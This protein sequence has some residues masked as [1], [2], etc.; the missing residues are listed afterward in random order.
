MKPV[1]R[2]FKDPGQSFFLFG[3]RGTGKSTWIHQAH[4]DALLVDLLRPESHRAFSARPERLRDVLEGNPRRGPVV[5]DEVQRVPALL[6]V[7]HALIEE[8]RHPRFILT[9]SSAR[10]I[11][12]ADVDLLGGRALLRTMHPF[13]ASE[14]GDRFR[15]AEALRRGTVPL[16][17]ASPLPE[18][19][20][21]GYVSLYI[22][23]EVKTEGLVRN[24]GTFARF[25]EAITFSHG[26]VLSVSNVARECEAERNTVE[27]YISILEDLLLAFRVPVFSKRAKRALASHPKFY[28]FDA[29]VFRS[30][31]PRGPLD[32]PE[33]IEGGALEGLVAQ[34]VR[35]WNAY[36]GERNALYYWRTRSGVEVDLILYGED[37]LWAIEVKNSSRI[38]SR[39]LRPLRT[40]SEDYPECKPVLLYRGEERLKVDGVSCIPCEEF[41][42][43]LHPRRAIPG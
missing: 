17:V 21:Q 8:K 5:I 41:L 19:T 23:Q 42:R 29:G 6:S 30:L 25:L 33:E 32:R 40:F 12:R 9:G 43:N 37:G 38:D 24:M 39:D 10:K 18:E 11:K 34:H 16:V 13:M 1:V 14:L 27:G 35:A 28:L 36:R 2:F 26:S 20:L 22:E 7:V 4:P 31:R 15:L 3:P